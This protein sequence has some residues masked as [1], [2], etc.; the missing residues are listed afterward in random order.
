MQIIESLRASIIG[1]G[2]RVLAMFRPDLF[3][4]TVVVTSCARH[5]LLN[6]TLTSFFKYNSFPIKHMIIVED[7]NQV[8]NALVSKFR[9]E[10]I[11]WLATGRRV[12]QIAAIDYAYSRVKTPYIFH[13]EDD[14]EFYRPGFIERSMQILRLQ[15]TC[16]Q[17]WLRAL[18]DTNEHPCEP[19]VFTK[20]GIS[21]QRLILDFQQG[22]WHGF[23]F[24]PG[25]RR[26]TEYVATGGFGNLTSFDFHDPWKTEIAIGRFYR[27]KGYFAAILCDQEGQGYVRHTGDNH[28]TAPPPE[29]SDKHH[30]SSE[31]ISTPA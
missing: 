9:S 11:E 1:L 14:W 8:A 20:H 30:S 15:P 23:S 22:K 7:G 16:L 10:P 21:W 5:D 17:V 19:R 12:G 2:L 6:N 3:G 28:H 26:L 24:N 25:L 27:R 13:L 18:G 4:V 31:N 29:F